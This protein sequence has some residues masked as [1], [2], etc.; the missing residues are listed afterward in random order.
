MNLEKLKY[1]IGKVEIPENITKKNL[2]DWISLL[3]R[4]PHELE[5]LVR[6]LSENQLD[7]TYRENGWTIRQVIHHCYDSHHNSYLR[8]KWALTEENPIIKA[9]DE[10]S[11][12]EL[13]DSK[14]A[15]ILLSLDAL[16]A[17]HAKW[18]YLI[19]G[20]TDAQLEKTFIHPSD[21]KE[22]SLKKN[23]AIY[24]WH[25]RHHYAHIEQL[26]IRKDWK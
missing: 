18:V 3:E 8:F 11:W 25:C 19:Q 23:I 14:T 12:A 7:V 21:N 10:V 20:L 17:L 15:P 22:I 26:L 2:E 9:Y 13:H 4:F 6:E 24:A 1:P 16:K 5:F